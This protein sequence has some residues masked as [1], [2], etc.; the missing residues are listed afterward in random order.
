M[1]PGWTTLLLLITSLVSAWMYAT[2]LQAI[3]NTDAQHPQA[4]LTIQSLAWEQFDK[5]GKPGNRIQAERLEQWASEDSARLYRP[6]IQSGAD[7]RIPWRAQSRQG[8]IFADR[9][10][11]LLQ[12]QVVLNRQLSDKQVR[13]ETEQLMIDLVNY[14]ATTRQPVSVRSGSWTIKAAGFRADMSSRKLDLLGQV[15]SYHE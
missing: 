12:R 1:K 11:L 7:R 10:T 9:Q 2:S 4:S 3:Q 14:T 15:E 13:I 5:Q 8:R 6:L